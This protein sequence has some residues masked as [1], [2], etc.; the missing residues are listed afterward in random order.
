MNINTLTTSYA[1]IGRLL[2]AVE[3]LCGTA[4]ESLT[5]VPRAHR[6]LTTAVPVRDPLR[7]LVEAALDDDTDDKAMD[8]QFETAAIRRLIS[9]ERRGIAAQAERELLRVFCQRLEQGAGDQ[10]VNLL[11]KP[12]DEAAQTLREALATVDIPHDPQAFIETATPQEVLAWQSVRPAIGTL[13]R[14]AD[15]VRAFGPGGTFPIVADPRSTDPGLEAGWL[16]PRAAICTDGDLL[17]ACAQFQKPNP[18]N[19]IRTSPWPKVDRHLHSV[20]SANERLRAWAEVEWQSRE[21]QRPTSG[22]LRPDGTILADVRR[23]PFATA[24]D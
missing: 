6:R 7:A 11:R 3:T 23:N 1:D 12:F 17:A 10:V 16:E 9:D 24:G 2:S 8:A 18:A 15:I 13:D 14:I 4:P 19:D 20:G 22:R 5:A 21:A